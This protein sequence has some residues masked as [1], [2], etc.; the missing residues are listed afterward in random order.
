MAMLTWTSTDYYLG[1]Q[2]DVVDNKDLTG[3]IA[4]VPQVPQAIVPAT[5]A[6][7]AGI[8]QKLK[9]AYYREN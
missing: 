8:W 7:N 2:R 3:E 9:N 5:E 6:K 4:E 1:R